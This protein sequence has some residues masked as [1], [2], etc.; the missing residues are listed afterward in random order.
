M[1]AELPA[2]DAEVPIIAMGSTSAVR[3]RPS[4][5][6]HILSEHPSAQNAPT[7]GENS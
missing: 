5:I 4:F 1:I 6:N 7:L 2:G 3:E